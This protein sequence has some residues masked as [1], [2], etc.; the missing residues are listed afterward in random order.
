MEALEDVDVIGHVEMPV[1]WHRDPAL[2]PHMLEPVK[3]QLSQSREQAMLPSKVTFRLGA[4]SV[5]KDDR[6]VKFKKPVT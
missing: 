4:I 6:L 1:H 3:S 5:S 2:Y